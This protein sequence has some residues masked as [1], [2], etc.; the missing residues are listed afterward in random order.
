MGNRTI[1][2]NSQLSDPSMLNLIEA[3][4]LGLVQGLTEWF[5][6]SSSGHLAMIQIILGVKVDIFLDIFLHLG[7]LLVIVVK[8]RDDI[9]V[10]IRDLIQ[11]RL[12]SEAAMMGL[13]LISGSVPTALIG[14]AF[15]EDFRSSFNDPFVIGTAFAIS[16]LVL[17]LSRNRT[18]GEHRMLKFS[19][20]ILIGVAQ[21]V[22]IIP[23]ISRSGLTISTGILL[24]L[25]RE[26]ALR[27]SF[28]LSIPAVLGAAL[29]ELANQP[30]IQIDY[31]GSLVGFIV[32]AVVGYA[33]L[34]LLWK[35]VERDQLHYFSYYCW[36][37]SCVAISYAMARML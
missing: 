15:Y 6:V 9:W 28:L 20:S 1:F 31:N 21:G 26:D 5:P 10:I 29:H 36:L 12:R 33:S 4:L 7:T 13:L 35:I 19:D 32:A 27:Y 37:A 34:S 11:G 18:Q 22:S 24:G 30:S 17:Y 8:F 16:G 3:I 25:K 2:I 14:F 23:G